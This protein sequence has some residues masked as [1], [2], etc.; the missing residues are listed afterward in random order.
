MCDVIRQHVKRG[1]ALL[2]LADLLPGVDTSVG[3]H[4]TVT[5]ERPP[6]DVTLV[7][8][9]SG[10]YTAV[11]RQST[12]LSKRPA[13]VVTAVRTF[14][15]VCPTMASHISHIVCGVL[16]PLTLVSPVSADVA[17]TPLHVSVQTILSQTRVVAVGT[18]DRAST[19]G[20]HV[21]GVSADKIEQIIV[22]SFYCVYVM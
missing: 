8:S 15:R 16:A 4:A 13:A 3:H 19:W 20:T 5:C 10:V 22:T 2:T 11:D 1:A 14:S 18:V 7:Q 21:T 9:L 17:V 12:P 6:T